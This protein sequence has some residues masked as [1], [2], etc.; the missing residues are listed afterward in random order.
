MDSGNDGKLL[1]LSITRNNL[2]MFNHWSSQNFTHSWMNSTL[3]HHNSHMLAGFTACSNKG[4]S[5]LQYRAAFLWWEAYHKGQSHTCASSFKH[6]A[7]INLSAATSVWS[8]GLPLCDLDPHEV[9]SLCFRHNSWAAKQT[10][11]M[12]SVSHRVTNSSGPFCAPTCFD[13]ENDTFLCNSFILCLL[14]K[15]SKSTICDWSQY[16]KRFLSQVEIRCRTETYIFTW[17]S[18]LHRIKFLGFS[19]WTKQEENPPNMKRPSENLQYE[20]KY[21]RL[22]LVKYR[23][24]VST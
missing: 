22:E 15:S 9:S 13:K 8:S 19:F 18:K 2:C 16:A 1:E 12:M 4:P 20:D 6:A 14:S 5:H 17:R 3:P 7:C 10:K 23:K 24:Y 21:P 11:S